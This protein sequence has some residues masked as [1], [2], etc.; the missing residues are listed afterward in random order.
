MRHGGTHDGSAHP[1]EA[2]LRQIDDEVG[3]SGVQHGDEGGADEGSVSMSMSP[4]M[5]STQY[6]Q[7]GQSQAGFQLPAEEPPPAPLL[8]LL[9]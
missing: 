6:F 1:A 9:G 4:A 2:D 3:R 8:L 5:C 7:L